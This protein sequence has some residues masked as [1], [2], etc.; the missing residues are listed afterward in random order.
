MSRVI[1]PQPQ[2]F[3]SKVFECGH[4]LLSGIV[5]H[6]QYTFSWKLERLVFSAA[7]L[8]EVKNSSFAGKSW[9]SLK[10]PEGAGQK[11]RKLRRESSATSQGEQAGDASLMLSA[12]SRVTVPDEIVE[13]HLLP[14]LAWGNLH[15][16]RG[17]L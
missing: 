5:D 14:E 4:C 15:S 6:C 11:R 17:L 16:F 8:V 10:M 9:A 13:G 7:N 1:C 12:S 2:P 3:W